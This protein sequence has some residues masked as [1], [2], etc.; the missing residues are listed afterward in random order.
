MKPN[1]PIITTSQQGSPIQLLC[2]FKLNT[3]GLLILALQNF[4]ITLAQPE[5]VNF[6]VTQGTAPKFRTSLKSSQGNSVN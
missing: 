4:L 2:H 6:I 3:D 5:G 1:P